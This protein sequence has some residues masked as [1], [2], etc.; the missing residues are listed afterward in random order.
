MKALEKIIHTLQESWFYVFIALVILTIVGCAPP[1]WVIITWYVIFII[2]Y[3]GNEYFYRRN[4]K[5]GTT[6][7]ND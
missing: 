7:E 2:I 5:K 4:Q 6:N 1:L 3:P